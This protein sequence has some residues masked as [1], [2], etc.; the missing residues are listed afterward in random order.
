[1]ALLGHGV[2]LVG[3]TG[4]SELTSTLPTD[5]L[6]FKEAEFSCLIRGCRKSYAGLL[7]SLHL[8]SR[9]DVAFAFYAT[10]VCARIISR[11]G[12]K[13]CQDFKVEQWY[14]DISSSKGHDR[15]IVYVKEQVC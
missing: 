10:Y 11:A 9:S 1:M 4:P 14:F 8:L 3:D 5:A 6:C 13:W 7:A 2:L 15:L 12:R